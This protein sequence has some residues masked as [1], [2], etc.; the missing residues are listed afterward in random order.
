MT[1]RRSLFQEKGLPL[2]KSRVELLMTYKENRSTMFPLPERDLNRLGLGQLILEI[3]TLVVGEGAR[4][5]LG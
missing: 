2:L 5:A 3:L 4:H 1:R